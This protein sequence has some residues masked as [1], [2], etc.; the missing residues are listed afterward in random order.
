[1]EKSVLKNLIDTASGRIPADLCIKNAKVINV[2]DRS[3]FDADIY[4][5]DDYIAGFGGPGFPEA[6]EVFDAKGSYIAPGLIDAHVHIESSHLCPAE[7]SRLVVPHGTT[8]VI[9]DPH[10]ICNVCGLDGFDY[11]LKATEDLTLK[12]FVQFPS[13]VPATPFENSG[14]V[15]GPDEVEER[16]GNHRVLGLGELMNYVGVCNSDDLV[17][18]K[19]A[20]SKEHGK[21]FFDGHC[22]GLGKSG[23]DAYIAAGALNDHEC[24]SPEGALAKIRRGMYIMLREGSATHNV[25]TLLPAVN[26]RN[27][28]RFMFCTDDR[29]PASIVNE[30]HIDNNIRIAIKHG[31]DPLTAITIATY[32]AANSFGLRN[33][34]VVAPGRLA[35]LILFDDLSDF[36]VRKVWASGKL[37][38]DEGQYLA[39]DQH[40]K[41]EKVSGKMNVKNFSRER[42]ALKLAS[43]RAKAIKIIPYSI[44]TD[45]SEVKVLRNKNGCWIRNDDDVVKIAV[46]ERHKGTGNVGLGLIQGFGLKGGAIALSIAHDSHNIIVAGD[47][48]E[49]MEAAVNCLVEMG[50]GLA[51]A[52]DGK[53]ISSIQHEIAGLMCDRPAHEVA[54]KIESMVDIARKKLSIPETVD[55]FMTLC[56]MALPVIPSLKI[57][58]MGLFDVTKFEH[59]PVEAEREENLI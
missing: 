31:L 8:T 37:V 36:R 7:F 6:K 16:I 41:P 24:I 30:G 51:I 59:V 29:Q 50:G 33:R 57:T 58:D 42:L 52:K 27:Y 28:H 9:A 39:K 40:V 4:I 13:C 3:I 46:V 43:D 23:L 32:T 26:D 25:V 19:I 56:F 54:E 12:V 53:V 17:L 11:M 21:D 55:P 5:S 44:V 48:D 15:L 2:L 22:P 35:D 18:D 49:D 10:E 47:S 20:V 38:A 45:A 34:G 1:M 14:A